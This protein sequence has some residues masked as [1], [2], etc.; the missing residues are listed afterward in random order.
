VSHVRHVSPRKAASRGNRASR[1]R[2]AT[3]QMACKTPCRQR[4]L[5]GNAAAADG[6]A[7][8]GRRSRG[9]G[10]GRGRGEEGGAPEVAAGIVRRRCRQPFRPATRMPYTAPAVTVEATAPIDGADT[11]RTEPVPVALTEAPAPSKRQ[12]WKPSFHRRGSSRNGGTV[13]RGTRRAAGRRPGNGRS[14]GRAP[15]PAA[16]PIIVPPAPAAPTSRNR[17]SRSAW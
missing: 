3:T 9:R 2:R 8:S 7:R 12:S 4:R 11:R 14:R 10:R 15:A 17:C 1:V 6:E 16:D 5:S 13:A